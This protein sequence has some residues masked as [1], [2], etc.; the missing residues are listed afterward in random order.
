MGGELFVESEPSVGSTFA[1]TL[2]L[3][4]GKAVNLTQGSRQLEHQLVRQ[5]PLILPD[6]ESDDLP[7]PPEGAPLILVVDDEPI[8]LHILRH[9]LQP[10]GCRI[11]PSSDGHD[12]LAKLAE[13]PVDPVSYT[14]LTLP[15]NI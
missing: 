15:T 12:A 6:W 11:L 2:P 5:Q 13:E 10:C 7:P 1:F 14:H 3:A 9:L 4:T 8:N